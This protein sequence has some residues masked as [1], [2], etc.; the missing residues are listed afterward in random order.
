MYGH[1]YTDVFNNYTVDQVYLFYKKC[2]YEE[3]YKQK[4]DAITMVHS[5]SYAT[6]SRT[7]ESQQSKNKMWDRFMKSLDIDNTVSDEKPTIGGFMNMF[8]VAGV[9]I[10]KH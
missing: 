8:K 4:E 2:K 7:K 9:P 3:T 10:K 1:N 5:I 6:P